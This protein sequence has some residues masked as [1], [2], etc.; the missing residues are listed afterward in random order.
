MLPFS[1][2]PRSY[3]LCPVL[4][5]PTDLIKVLYRQIKSSTERYLKCLAPT[6]SIALA[7]FILVRK[8]SSKFSLE[9][10]KC[11]NQRHILSPS[12]PVLFHLALTTFSESSNPSSHNTPTLYLILVALFMWFQNAFGFVLKFLEI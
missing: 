2:L 11:L 5:T 8:C 1:G 9:S 4:Q 12:S 10:K 7:F 6:S 3:L